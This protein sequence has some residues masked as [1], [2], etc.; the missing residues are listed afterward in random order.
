[1]Q[2]VEPSIDLPL[3]LF[4]P[5]I[6]PC[7][8]S[9][10]WRYHPSSCTYQFISPHISFHIFPSHHS[11]SHVHLSGKCVRVCVCQRERERDN[12]RKKTVHTI[13]Y[14]TETGKWQTVEA[15]CVCVSF[16]SLYLF[17]FIFP[18]PPSWCVRLFK[19]SFHP[20]LSVS[21]ANL[22]S[23][24]HISGKYQQAHV[25]A[26]VMVGGGERTVAR[27]IHR[28]TAGGRPPW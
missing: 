18:P 21:R 9:L 13:N 1:M 11:F 26:R 17:C 2:I 25:A 4:L 5:S 6:P 3:A 15:I 23:G 7:T 27:L 12:L 14:S 19:F 10:L 24:G 28:R 20:S 16:V 22:Q 8:F